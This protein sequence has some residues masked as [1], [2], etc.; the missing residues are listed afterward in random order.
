MGC[1]VRDGDDDVVDKVVVDEDVDGGE[2]SVGL[3]V[4]CMA[5]CCRILL[6][7]NEGISIP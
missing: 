6:P 1:V 7:R 3:Q 2:G 5:S 4:T